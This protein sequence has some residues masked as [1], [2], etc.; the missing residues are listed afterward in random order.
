[1][2]Y[3]DYKRLSLQKRFLCIIEVFAVPC[4]FQ[5]EPVGTSWILV[6]NFGVEGLPNK[7]E[8]TLTFSNRI[9]IRT[10]FLISSTGSESEQF[11]TGSNW[12]WLVLEG[13]VSRPVQDRKKTRPRP[14]FNK[15]CSLGLSNFKTK[16][17]KKTGLY[18]SV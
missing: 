8:T 4:R 7:Q 2:K 12:F 15:D 13:P 1:M 3:S 14:V 10:G 6:R 16:D 9:P 11:P 18:G 17:R 5:S